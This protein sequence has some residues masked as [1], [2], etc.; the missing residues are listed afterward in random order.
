MLSVVFRPPAEAD[1]LEARAWYARHSE[2]TAA[3]FAADLADTVDRVAEHPAGF[4]RVH[5]SVRRAVLH[6]FP[7][8]VCYN[9]ESEAVVV[10]AVQGRQDPARWKARA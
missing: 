6:R 3:R 9:V 7:C 10:L 2:T 5:G 1:A 4:A 8:A